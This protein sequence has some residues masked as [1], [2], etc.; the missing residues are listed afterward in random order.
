MTKE[1]PDVPEKHPYDYGPYMDFG[2]TFL[3]MDNHGETRRCRRKGSHMMWN[4]Q[5]GNFDHYCSLHMPSSIP[6]NPM[7]RYDESDSLRKRL[8]EVEAALAD[9]LDM[10]DGLV[11]GL[12]GIPIVV[13]DRQWSHTA[14]LSVARGSIARIRRSLESDE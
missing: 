14:M 8:V 12:A 7:P 4:E 11:L 3:V 9:T 2:C 1:T 13:Y 6:D 5:S 10:L